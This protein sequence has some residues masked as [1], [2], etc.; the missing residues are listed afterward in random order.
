MCYTSGR[1]PGLWGEK[2]LRDDLVASVVEQ[3][4]IGKDAK[5]LEVG[6]ASG[7]LAKAIAPSVGEYVGIDVSGPAVAVARR[8]ELSNGKFEVTDGQRIDLPCDSFDAVLCYDV[9]TNFPSVEEFA[10]LLEEMIRVVK[11]GG[12]VMVGSIPDEEKKADAARLGE[13][14]IEEYGA[15]E[16]PEESLRQRFY[17]WISRRLKEAE[18]QIICYTFDKDAVRNLLDG[19]LATVEIRDIHEKNPYFGTRFNAIWTKT[20]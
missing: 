7:F 19:S 17:R 10:S 11:P 3:L 20:S 4:R 1:H 18:I 15:F 2:A 8:L 9:I 13:K 5:L 16:Q 6:C 12:R 14:V